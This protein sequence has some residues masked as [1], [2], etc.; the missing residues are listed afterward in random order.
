MKI[1]KKLNDDELIIELDGRLDTNTSPDLQW[2]LDKHINS[3][4]T[5][6][7]DFK[8]LMYISSAGLRVILSTQKIMNEQGTMVIKNVND[9]VMEVFEATGFADIL[10]IE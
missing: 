6:I 10:N 8:N 7:F 3:I 4:K 5:L 1:N 9:L 2:E